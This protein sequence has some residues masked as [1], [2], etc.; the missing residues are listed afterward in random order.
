MFKSNILINCVLYYLITTMEVCSLNDWTISACEIFLRSG[1][2]VVSTNGVFVQLVCPHNI[3]S[4][5]R[6]PTE[7][8]SF[9]VIVEIISGVICVVTYLFGCWR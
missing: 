6:S 2:G 1:E 9:G 5:D 4:T 8:S 7:E 3:S